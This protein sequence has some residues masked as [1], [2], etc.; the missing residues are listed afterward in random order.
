MLVLAHLV[1][2]ARNEKRSTLTW[3]D[4]SATGFSRSDAP[5]SATLQFAAPLTTTISAWPIRQSEIQHKL[6]KTQKALPTFGWDTSPVLGGE[7]AVEEGFLDVFCDLLYGTGW[8]DRWEQTFRECNWVLVCRC[9]LSFQELQ[10]LTAVTTTGGI[11]VYAPVPPEWP[12]ACRSSY[13]RVAV[14]L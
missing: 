6:K 12:S 9:L 1:V 5:L 8:V 10:T 2:Q 7:E 4:F 13:G 14:A 3:S 11:Q